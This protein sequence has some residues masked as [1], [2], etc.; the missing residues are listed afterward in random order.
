MFNEVSLKL[1][2]RST[3]LHAKFCIHHTSSHM[4]TTCKMDFLTSRD[5]SERWLK[6][7]KSQKPLGG[8]SSCND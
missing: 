7:M 3:L 4:T 6:A 5:F 1:N 2:M 8:G